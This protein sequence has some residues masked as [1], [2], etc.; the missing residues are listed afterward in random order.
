VI[1]QAGD[2]RRAVAHGVRVGRDNSV[3][4]ERTIVFV[5][6]R[7]SSLPPVDVHDLDRVSVT[8]A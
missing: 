4:G 2:V 3:G 7:F 1:A 8:L 6:R 5:V